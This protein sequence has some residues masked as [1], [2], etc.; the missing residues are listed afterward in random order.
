M[1]FGD[2]LTDESEGSRGGNFEWVYIAKKVGSVGLGDCRLKGCACR[3][4]KLGRCQGVESWRG[5]ESG[6]VSRK[7]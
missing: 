4:W 5:Y 1:G 2:V 3:A 7:V 6:S